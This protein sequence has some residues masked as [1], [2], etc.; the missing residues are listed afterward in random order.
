MDAEKLKWKVEFKPSFDKSFRKCSNDDRKRILE[1][2]ESLAQSRNPVRL[3]ESLTS[4]FKGIIKFR[5]GK[6]RFLYEVDWIQHKI[7]FI[8]LDNRGS[9]YGR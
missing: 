9:V 4:D 8:D 3:G 1:A 2:I 6:I 7:I 5:V